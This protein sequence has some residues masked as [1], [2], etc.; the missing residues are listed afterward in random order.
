MRI[1]II[2][3]IILTSP[4]FLIGKNNIKETKISRILKKNET[5]KLLSER[6]V[7]PI[8]LKVGIA[9]PG[10]YF[11][12]SI[13]VFVTKFLN[14]EA[15]TGTGFFG[16]THNGPTRFAN[17][18]YHAPFSSNNDQ[19]SFFGGIGY[20]N[21]N[22][23]LQW[24]SYGRTEH[25]D[26]IYLASGINYIAYSGFTFK[27]EIGPMYKSATEYIGYQN[28]TK[29]VSGFTGYFGISLGF[30]FGLKDNQPKIKRQKS[31]YRDE[32]YQFYNN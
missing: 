30:H 18:T 29:D 3:L 31:T 8:G 16:L 2:I 13:D 20:T 12:I 27:L 22:L 14:I 1:M 21:Y 24:T 25:V 6:Q 7:K 4:Q 23:I 32:N 26:G 11:N 10:S 28:Q 19:W 15:G 5:S 17:I 9:G